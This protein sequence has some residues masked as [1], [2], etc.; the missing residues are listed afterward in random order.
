MTV[1]IVD[2]EAN[3]RSS[4]EGALGREGYQ[5][6]G[7][8]SIAEGRARLRE[9]YDIVLLD[10]WFEEGSGLDLLAEIMANTPDS[11]VIMMSGHATVDAAVK[12]TRLGAFDFLEKPISLERLL[13]LLRNATNTIALKAEN[14]R[15]PRPWSFPIVG[16]SPAIQKLLHEI[17]LAG[18][19]SARVLIQGENG[20]GKELVARA[21]HAS[22]PRKEMPFVAMNCSAVPE[23]LIESELF[24]H[25]RGAFTGA[26]QS[27][28]GRFEEAHHGTLFLDEIGDMSVRAQTKL[29]RVLE[30]GEITRV[31]G[32]RAIKV[33]V[34]VIAATNQDLAERVRSERFREDLYFRLAVIPITVPPLRDRPEDI[35]ILVEH[36][37]EQLLKQ[38]GGKPR[39]FTP[40]ALEYLRR[41][42]FPG[43]VRELRNIVERL[44]IMSRGTSIG[45]EQVHAVLP[46]SQSESGAGARLSDAVREF[47]KKEIEAA[48]LAAGGSM[49]KAASRL[50]L[51]RSHL[52]KK[53]KK[54]GWRPE[55]LSP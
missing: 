1:L 47:E 32:N 22:G 37:A 24:G 44:L 42:S 27:R 28:R 34:R 17:Q 36:F 52:Y 15:L 11:I 9:A 14:R 39:K 13:V 29:L 51:E 7:A 5:V 40:A 12:A 33:D 16:G 10:V 6:D 35:P 21:L 54:L 43:N 8:A 26:T 20:T 41:Y 4:L 49:T 3:I 2:D 38:N 48:L 31:G 46:P 18:S 30:E 53:M 55:T 50:G 25:E 45:P 23:E 19:S